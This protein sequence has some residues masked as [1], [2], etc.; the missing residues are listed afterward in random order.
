MYRKPMVHI[1][2][3][4]EQ[5]PRSLRRTSS[6]MARRFSASEA[7]DAVFRP[8]SDESGGT[9]SDPDSPGDLGMSSDEES[10]LDR[11]LRGETDAEEEVSKV[12]SEQS[13]DVNSSAASHA[14]SAD[15]P[16]D[17]ARRVTR[18]TAAAVTPV[19]DYDLDSDDD[20][21]SASSAQSDRG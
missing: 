2:N 19:V 13:S 11:A 18:L 17:Q 12:E 3:F 15:S 5:V 14:R 21:D 10:D 4:L 1:Q 6:A 8:D 9:S 20:F 7:L 16:P